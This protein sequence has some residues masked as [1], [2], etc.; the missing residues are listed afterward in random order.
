MRSHSDFKFSVTLKSDD[1]GAVYCLRAL[2]DLSQPGGDNKIAWGGTGR[3][4]WARDAHQVT[5]RFTTPEFRAAFLQEAT[6]LLHDRWSV[7]RENNDDPAR[8]R[9]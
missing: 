4:E 1:I 2:T 3:K 9:R 7:V 6:R 5:F 8:P